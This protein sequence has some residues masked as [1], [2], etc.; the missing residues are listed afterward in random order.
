[1]QCACILVNRDDFLAYLESQ[2]DALRELDRRKGADYTQQTDALA[3]LRDMPRA[4]ITGRQRLWVLLSKHLAAIETYIREG[5]VESE[6]IETRIQDAVLYLLLLGALVEEGKQ[7]DG[8]TKLCGDSCL[9]GG[10]AVTCVLD[11]GHELPHRSE[12]G[13]EW[14][15]VIGG[16]RISGLEAERQVIHSRAGTP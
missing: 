16:S 2:F 7:G 4:G 1:V 3:N 10:Y 12:L 9:L 6:P 15:P 8:G 14:L 5:Q 11:V 13:S